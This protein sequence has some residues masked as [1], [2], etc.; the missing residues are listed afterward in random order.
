MGI[1]LMGNG[2]RTFRGPCDRQR[3]FRKGTQNKEGMKGK[4][5]KAPEVV[6]TSDTCGRCHLRFAH[7]S[8]IYTSFWIIP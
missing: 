2:F 7:P 6:K 8:K 4:G 3:T 5:C 1:G